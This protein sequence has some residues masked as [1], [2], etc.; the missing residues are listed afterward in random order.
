MKELIFSS[1]EAERAVL[2]RVQV[3]LIR[4]EER[5]RWDGEIEQ[6]HYLKNACLVGEQLR[7]VAE[8]DGQWAALLGWSAGSYHLRQREAWIGWDV[9]Q[10]RQRLPLVA[11][12]ARFLILEP[13]RWP[14]L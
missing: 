2:E 3:R 1:D 14:K 10:R 5:A 11:N 7:Y 4:A 12:N 6:K 8:V 13:G 9:E